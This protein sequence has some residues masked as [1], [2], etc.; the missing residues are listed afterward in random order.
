MHSIHTICARYY[1]HTS[2][3]RTHAYMHGYILTVKTAFITTG[4]R[5]TESKSNVNDVD[6]SCP[7]KPC[8]Q[9]SEFM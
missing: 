2:I 5:E 4:M 8:S 1:I 9:L 6:L 7:E 3:H